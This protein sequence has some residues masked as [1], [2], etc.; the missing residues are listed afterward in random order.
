MSF[1][2]AGY[3]DS[4]EDDGF[5][6]GDEFDGG[7]FDDIPS[8]ATKPTNGASSAP[9]KPSNHFQKTDFE[10]SQVSS[11]QERLNGGISHQAPVK[12]GSESL[13][14]SNSF[15]SGISQESSVPRHSNNPQEEAGTVNFAISAEQLDSSSPEKSKSYKDPI[16]HQHAP[17]SSFGKAVNGL[18]SSSQDRTSSKKQVKQLEALEDMRVALSRGNIEQVKKLLDEGTRLTS[19]HPAWLDQ[20]CCGL[21]L[22]RLGDYADD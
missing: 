14:S 22:F 10:N 13:L 20:H 6:F 5:Y 9:L 11:N 2:P 8:E 19:G 21:V 16:G 18:S 1:V 3:Y 12:G 15:S 4:E 17:F 7:Q